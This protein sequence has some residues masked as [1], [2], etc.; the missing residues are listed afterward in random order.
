MPERNSDRL[1][2]S[3]GD[4][5]SFSQAMTILA[6]LAPERMTLSQAIFFVLAG[7]ADLAGQDPT[8]SEIKLAV[9]DKINRS[10]N[11]TYRILLGPSRLYPNGL[12]WLRQE[13][14][15]QDNREK[16]LR[17][18]DEGRRVLDQVATAIDGSRLSVS[19]MQGEA[20]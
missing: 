2:T 19:R 16:F 8:Y 3:A 18:T 9:G 10:L 14:N 4:L 13:I 6:D 12:G 7:T 11:T 17:L 15:P 5:R 1:F 20:A